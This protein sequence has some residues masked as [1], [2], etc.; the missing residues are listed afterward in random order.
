MLLFSPQKLSSIFMANVW[1]VF[2]TGVDENFKAFKTELITPY[3]QGVVLD[4]GA[5]KFVQLIK[6]TQV[7]YYFLRFWTY[8]EISRPLQGNKVHCFGA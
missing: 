1:T 6:V 7:S 3:A 5:G 4:V 2:G 8:V